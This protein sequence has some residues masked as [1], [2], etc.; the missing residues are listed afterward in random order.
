MDKDMIK[1]LLALRD[2]IEAEGPVIH[3]EERETVDVY[4]AMTNR[5]KPMSVM[6]LYTEE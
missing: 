1:L 3:L 5:P 4:E 2:R 6:D